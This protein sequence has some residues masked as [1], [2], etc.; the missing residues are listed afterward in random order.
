LQADQQ[1]KQS[2]KEKLI[3]IQV[4]KSAYPRK[5]LMRIT[6]RDPELADFV[7]CIEPLPGA[8]STKRLR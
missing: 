7:Y 2:E 1:D 4:H 5:E 8:A 6:R 3:T